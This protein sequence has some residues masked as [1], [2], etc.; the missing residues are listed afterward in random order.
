MLEQLEVQARPERAEEW[1]K[2]LA[3]HG[4]I[5]DAQ[6]IAPAG[7]RLEIVF[8]SEHVGPLNHDHGLTKAIIDGIY[9]RKE[10]L[11]TIAFFR[12]DEISSV[13]FL[14]ER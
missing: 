10:H 8:G 3:E 6:I 14:R 11:D 7:R 2:L 4:C 13:C 5:R 12:L 9:L 1:L